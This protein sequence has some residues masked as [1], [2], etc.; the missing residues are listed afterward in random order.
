MILQRSIKDKGK[1]TQRMQKLLSYTNIQRKSKI[2]PLQNSKGFFGI[3]SEG[4]DY[5]SAEMEV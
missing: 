1:T 3:F 2:K 4:A 5:C